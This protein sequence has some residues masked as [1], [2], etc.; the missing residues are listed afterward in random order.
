MDYK[1]RQTCNAIITVISVLKH[2][3]LTP[4]EIN[5]SQAVMNSLLADADKF[6]VPWSLQNSLLY[7]GEV[8]DVRFWYIDQLFTKACERIAAS[9]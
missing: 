1:S 4:D 9:R 7:I 5:D 2:Q 8:Y 6:G 3:Q